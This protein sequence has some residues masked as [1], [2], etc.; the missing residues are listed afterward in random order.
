MQ[1]VNLVEEGN[2]GRGELDTLRLTQLASRGAQS[3]IQIAAFSV[4]NF[5]FQINR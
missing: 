2:R 3:N 1:D 4:H 5:I